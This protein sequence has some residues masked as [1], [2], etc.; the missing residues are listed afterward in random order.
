MN[1]VQTFAFLYLPFIVMGMAVI[2][3]VIFEKVNKA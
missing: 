1:D 2:A 3:V